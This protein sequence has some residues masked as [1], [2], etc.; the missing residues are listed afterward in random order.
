MLLHQ[1]IWRKGNRHD[2]ETTA[3]LTCL[4]ANNRH[5]SARV[6]RIAV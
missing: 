1:L 3:M 4:V 2:L 6:G 5:Q